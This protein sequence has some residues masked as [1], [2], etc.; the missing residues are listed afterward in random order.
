MRSSRLRMHLCGLRQK[1]RTPKQE[2]RLFVRSECESCGQLDD[3]RD[4]IVDASDGITSG[5]NLPEQSARDAGGWSVPQRVIEQVEE[6][7]SDFEF[8][9][10][11][12]DAGTFRNGNVH[13]RSIGTAEG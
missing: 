5:S 2:G 3:S 8:C 10:V 4:R 1:V 12:V 13:Q 6:V 7:G 11:A 9:P